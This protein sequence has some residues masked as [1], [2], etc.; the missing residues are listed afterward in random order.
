MQIEKHQLPDGTESI[1]LKVLEAQDREDLQRQLGKAYRKA[2]AEPTL[3]EIKQVEF[4]PDDPCPCGSKRKA[5]NCCAGRLLR[6]LRIEKLEKEA[7]EASE[8]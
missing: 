3:R 8:K 4:D 7:A 1:R 5:K 2:R 6:R